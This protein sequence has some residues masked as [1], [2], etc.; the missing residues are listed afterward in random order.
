MHYPCL[1]RTNLKFLPKSP[2]PKAYLPDIAD[3]PLSISHITVS[4]D[5]ETICT[6]YGVDNSVTT[7]FDDDTVD[8]G[9]PQTQTSGSCNV[10]YH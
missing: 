4:G 6:F 8:V 2:P 1:I 3:N 9:P 5:A 7:V 10:I